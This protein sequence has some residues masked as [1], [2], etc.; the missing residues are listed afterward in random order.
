MN[1]KYKSMWSSSA[2]SLCGYRNVCFLRQVSLQKYSEQVQKFLIDM[3]NK[4]FS[5]QQQ[6]GKW[7]ANY[8]TIQEHLVYYYNSNGCKLEGNWKPFLTSEAQREN[9]REKIRELFKQMLDVAAE[10]YEDKKPEMSIF[11]DGV[12]LILASDYVEAVNK[13]F[14]MLKTAIKKNNNLFREDVQYNC[15]KPVSHSYYR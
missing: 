13:I 2:C 5:Y 1:Q 14:S 15:C 8:W 4:G 11:L 7:Y 9:D 10:V 6:V 3:L 12:G